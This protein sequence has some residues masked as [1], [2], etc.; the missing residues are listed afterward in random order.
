MSNQNK[1]TKTQAIY[2]KNPIVGTEDF[3]ATA[4]EV[5]FSETKLFREGIIKEKNGDIK[6]I[7]NTDNLIINKLKINDNTYSFKENEDFIDDLLFV[8]KD[9]VN[10][11]L[12][13]QR[14][15]HKQPSKASFDYNTGKVSGYLKKAI[16]NIVEIRDFNN[17][18]DLGLNMVLE[19]VAR[20]YICLNSEEEFEKINKFKAY[21]GKTAEIL[22]EV[23]NDRNPVEGS[24]HLKWLK[25]VGYIK[26]E[27]NKD[28]LNYNEDS[29][30]EAIAGTTTI[31]LGDSKFIYNGKSYEWLNPTKYKSMI[32]T[33]YLK[34]FGTKLDKAQREE[35]RE[36]FDYYLEAKQNEITLANK[37]HAV[38]QVALAFKNGTLYINK[39]GKYFKHNFWNPQD[40]C[41]IEFAMDYK[42]NYE[43]RYNHFSTWALTRFDTKEKLRFFR[44]IMGDL[45]SSHATTDVHGYF[46]GGAGIGKSTLAQIL[47]DMTT[48]GTVGS[49]KL[50]KIADKFSRVKTL[51]S[52]ILIADEVSGD[53]FSKVS[54]YKSAISRDP[55]DYEMKNVQNFNGQPIAKFISFANVEMRI[56]MDPGVKRRLC[57]I[58]VN[59]TPVY[60]ELSPQE[61]GEAFGKCKYE[62]LEFIIE[63]IQ[64][65]F[66]INWDIKK[67]YDENFQDEI[68]A[69][70]R[71][72][73]S[74]SYFLSLYTDLDKESSK[75]N[76]VEPRDLFRLFNKFLTTLEGTALSRLSINAFGAKVLSKGIKKKR[77]KVKGSQKNR[78]ECLVLNE[79]G[80]NFMNEIMISELH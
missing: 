14:L 48:N 77:V 42:E 80:K 78:Y 33:E 75:E 46:W 8:R 7:Y 54:E 52:P 69:I 76:W 25:Q 38:K 68:Q 36:R 35:L 15:E 47:N 61:F 26:K 41:F 43:K 21:K 31:A 12:N 55:D 1:T 72:N 34:Q 44:M 3:L 74:V 45:F 64:D 59:D 30:F 9:R 16:E 56:K 13:M 71:K 49:M 18:I 17:G 22:K 10:N 53:N 62:I 11:L 65:N 37:T 70:E 32:H 23:D 66:T 63:G 58:K 51:H 60:T 27:S 50:D 57:S 73:D 6:L 2:I 29:V 67:F 19:E 5:I 20:F 28:V 4:L 40:N 79:Y 39:T 24:K